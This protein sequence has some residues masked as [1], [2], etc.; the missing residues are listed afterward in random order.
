MNCI[1]MT[2]LMK[3]FVRSRRR[4][5]AMELYESM[6]QNSSQVKPDMITYSMLIKA[7]CDG[8]DMHTALSILEDMR[9]ADIKPSIYTLNAMV[10]VYGKCGQTEKAVEM[11]VRMQE[12]YSLTPSVVIYTCLVS[13]LLRVKKYAEAWAQFEK[14]R[15]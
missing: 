12:Q 10:K 6:K 15:E 1:A 8:Q 5:K 13:G 4:D 7:H 11:V 9:A 2:T 14:M 3:G